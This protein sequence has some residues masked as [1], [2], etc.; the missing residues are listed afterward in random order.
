[1]AKFIL[2]YTDDQDPD[3]NTKRSVSGLV[4]AVQAVRDFLA[5]SKVW[6]EGIAAQLHDPSYEDAL[7][8]AL[9]YLLEREGHD[10]LLD[11]ISSLKVGESVEVGVEKGT[12]SLSRDR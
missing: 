5:D 4:R 3:R 6:D 1:M 12:F 10:T 8:P 9:E 7:R 11:L 2:T